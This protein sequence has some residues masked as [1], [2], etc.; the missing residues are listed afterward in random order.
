[1]SRPHPKGGVS[2]QFIIWSVNIAMRE[3]EIT[4][5]WYFYFINRF[6]LFSDNKL[7]KTAISDVGVTTLLPRG[8]AVLATHLESDPDSQF[9]GVCLSSSKL[10]N[11]YYTYI[12]PPTEENWSSLIEVL[13]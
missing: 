5:I 11:A 1:M 4:R 6:I 7:L 3:I 2:E 13:H 8:V 9:S 10:I 12:Q